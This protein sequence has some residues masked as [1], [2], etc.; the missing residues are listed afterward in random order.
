MTAPLSRLL[1]AV[2]IRSL[3]AHRR[4]WGMAM[5]AEFDAAVADRRPLGFALGCLFMA[6]RMPR[7]AARL[8]A[9]RWR[10]A[11]CCRRRCW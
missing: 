2:A 8:P 1:L 6:W 3:P 10:S 4:G 7:D 5:A 9:M 11:C